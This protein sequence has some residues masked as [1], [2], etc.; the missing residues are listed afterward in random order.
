MAKNPTFEELEKQFVEQKDAIEKISKLNEIFSRFGTNS[1]TNIDVVVQH[2]HKLLQ[3]V[4]C[5]YNRFD[6]DEHSLIA[7]AYHN[8]PSDFNYKDTPDGH[9]C[10]EATM[11]EKDKPVVIGDIG[12]TIYH[13]T[14]PNVKKY[15]LKSYLGFPVLLGGSTIGA[16]CIV[17]TKEREFSETEIHII[18]T[19]AKVVSL[20]EER[21]QT[22]KLL[23]EREKWH[24]NFLENMGDGV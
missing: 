5:L 10:Y 18:S 4:C 9:I 3:G 22:E 12:S 21:S 2:A 8:L 17:D 6:N 19:L 23:Q 14:D 24:R 1:R 20:E 15:G 11:N 16:L 13:D 7:W